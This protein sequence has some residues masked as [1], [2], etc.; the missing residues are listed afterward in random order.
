MNSYPP[1]ISG[2]EALS[3]GDMSSENGDG[4]LEGYPLGENLFGSECRTKV[5]TSV[6]ISDRGV[7]SSVGISVSI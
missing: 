3:S 4:K 5:G 1:L 6:G 7:G 2:T